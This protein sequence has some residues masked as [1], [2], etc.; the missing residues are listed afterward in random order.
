[1]SNN[2]NLQLARLRST[3][4]NN[5]LAYSAN[6]ILNSGLLPGALD[7]RPPITNNLGVG[8]P[9]YVPT[10]MEISISL[11]PIQSRQQ[12]SKNFSLENFASGQG[13]KGGFW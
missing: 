1:L 13:L 9:T 5:P 7:F 10:K 3:I 12:V 8:N 11:L 6:R 2:T 4:A